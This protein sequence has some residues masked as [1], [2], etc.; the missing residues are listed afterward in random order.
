MLGAAA[1]YSDNPNFAKKAIDLRDKFSF[2]DRRGIRKDLL[3]NQIGF[4]LAKDSDSMQEVYEKA[5]VLA[6]Q[7]KLGKFK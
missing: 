2:D 7:K 5:L 6:E 1:Y 4:D 3:N